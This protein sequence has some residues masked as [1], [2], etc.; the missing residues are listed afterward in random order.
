MFRFVNQRGICGGLPLRVTRDDTVAEWAREPQ[1][2][3]AA[4]GLAGPSAFTDLVTSTSRVAAAPAQI[5]QICSA[6][7]LMQLQ[8]KPAQ[9]GG[10]LK[11]FVHNAWQAAVS[12]V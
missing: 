7:I 10:Y 3:A 9:N 5:T 11:S 12:A 4:G 8:P 2:P 6:G 1:L